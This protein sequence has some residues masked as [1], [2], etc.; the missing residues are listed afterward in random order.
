M[1]PVVALALGVTFRGDVVTTVSIIGVV[2]VIIGALMASR[3][4]A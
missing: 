4:E 3:S 2:L 1:I